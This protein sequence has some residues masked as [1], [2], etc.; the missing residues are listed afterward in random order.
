MLNGVTLFLFIIE[1]KGSKGY[2]LYADNIFIYSFF[3][4]IFR[5]HEKSIKKLKLREES[6]VQKQKARVSEK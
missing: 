1:L 2:F 5:I 4:D 3:R 6:Y